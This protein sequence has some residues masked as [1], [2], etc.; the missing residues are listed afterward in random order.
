MCENIKHGIKWSSSKSP[1][2]Q[3]FHQQIRRGGLLVCWKSWRRGGGAHWALMWHL[4]RRVLYH[5]LM[6]DY[7][8]RCRTSTLIMIPIDI[9]R[10]SDLFKN[11]ER[12]SSSKI[13]QVRAFQRKYLKF[14][15]ENLSNTKQKSFKCLWSYYDHFLYQI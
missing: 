12:F 8:W 15:K 2:I 6:P 3:V 9:W 14:S 1:I 11:K 4:A 13:D 7:A 10:N 5:C